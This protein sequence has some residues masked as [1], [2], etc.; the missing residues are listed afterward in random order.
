[1]QEN[2]GL[3]ASDRSSGTGGFA[4]FAET[5]IPVTG[6]PADAGATIRADAAPLRVRDGDDAGCLNLNRAQLPRLY[7]VN[8]ERMSELGA[9][10]GKRGTP[11][12]TRAEDGAAGG[13]PDVWSLL[14]EDMGDGSVPGIVGD[15]NTAMWGLKKRVGDTLAYRDELGG[16]FL[17]RVVGVLPMRLSL[18]DG[19][20]LISDDSFTRLFPSE[21]GFRAFLVDAGDEPAP[22]L[23]R[24]MNRDLEQ[25]GM[26]AV[27]AVDRL[28]EFHAVESTYLAMFLVLGGL[29]LVLG[30]GGLG[31]VVLRNGFE[32]RQEFALLD[33]LGF[34]KAKILWIVLGENAGL[35]AA[36]IL[37]GVAAAAVSI[38][39]VAVYSGTSV[40]V[41]VQSALLAVII[42]ANAAAVIVATILAMPK[43]PADYLREE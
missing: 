25:Y 36:G 9:F 43:A 26:Q 20:L 18:F 38:V 37:V 12:T 7:G 8:P 27:L 1:M 16:E 13:R 3:H 15:S 35:A 41:G 2:V 23:A 19:S 6:S 29:G 30:A 40:S 32:R 10:V 21:P 39:P 11:P 22:D 31:V 42:G 33:A 28:R 17:I 14:G 24:R 4:V 5:T 34:E